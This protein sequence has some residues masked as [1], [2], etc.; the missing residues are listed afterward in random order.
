MGG[1]RE[2]EEGRYDDEENVRRR[3]HSKHGGENSQRDEGT[4]V[5]NLSHLRISLEIYYVTRTEHPRP[6]GTEELGWPSFGVFR[7][8]AAMPASDKMFTVALVAGMLL[9]E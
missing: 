2:G 3:A 1:G 6:F 5:Q 9:T 4:I 8:A 7:I